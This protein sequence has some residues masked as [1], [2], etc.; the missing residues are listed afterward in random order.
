ML[1]DRFDHVD[2]TDVSESQLANAV[3]RANVTY[4]KMAAEEPEFES[5]SF[6]LVTV[7]QAAHWFDLDP[8]FDGVKRVLKPGGVVALWTYN[9]LHAGEAVDA[10]VRRYYGEILGRY[11]PPE[12]KMVEEGYRNIVFPFE[13]IR[14]PAFAMEAAW[15]LSG[16]TGFFRTWS[17]RQIYVEKNGADPLDLVERELERAWGPR[18]E[19]KRIVWPIHMRVGRVPDSPARKEP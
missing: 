7:S 11:W 16:L 13:E 2:A 1:A 4:R 10:V 9:L 18:G 12:R 19:V 14:A 8:F 17:A 5:A 15:D 3:A 6:D